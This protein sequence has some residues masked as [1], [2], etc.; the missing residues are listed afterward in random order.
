LSS[1]SYSTSHAQQHRFF[2]P[3]WHKIICICHGANYLFS[4]FELSRAFKSF[5]VNYSLYKLNTI[6]DKN[7]ILVKLIFYY[8]PFLSALGPVLV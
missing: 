5:L 3:Q 7:S 2:V 1:F 8:S 4:Y 6:G